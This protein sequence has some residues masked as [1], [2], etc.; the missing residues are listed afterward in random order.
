M[1]ESALERRRRPDGPQRYPSRSDTDEQLQAIDSA[2][3]LSL[4]S[5]EFARQILTAI[6]TRSLPAREIADRLD[7]S[8]ATVYRRLNRLEEAGLVESTMSYHAEGHHRKQF[9]ATLD[10]VEVAVTDDGL[11]LDKA[12]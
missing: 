6:S 9:Q 10:R 8:R 2:E 11:V 3:V 5:N 12:E 7:I 1:S 4:L